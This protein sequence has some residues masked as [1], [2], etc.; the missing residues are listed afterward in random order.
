MKKSASFLVFFII[1]NFVC[2][3]VMAKVITVN[4]RLDIA[5]A[6]YASLQLAY[7]NATSGDTI[8]LFPSEIAYIGIDIS[9][10]LFL[11]GNGFVSSNYLPITIISGN[12]NFLEGSDGSS[13]ES[14]G[15]VFNITVKNVNNILISKNNINSLIIE[16]SFNTLL[17]SNL[18]NGSYTLGDFLITLKGNSLVEAKSNIIRARGIPCGYSS[19]CYAGAILIE[20][21]SVM[22]IDNS[23]IYSEGQLTIYGGIAQGKNNI[24]YGGLRSNVDFRFSIHSNAW[25]GQL[26]VS[27][28]NIIVSDISSIFTDLSNYNYHLKSGSEAIGNGEDGTDM[29]IYGGDT[30]FVDGG[31]PG[32]PVIYY[33]DV[34]LKGSQKQGINVTIK[35]KSNQ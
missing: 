3:N 2:H 21:S 25:E 7:D 12:V 19:T 10:R 23:I 14:F 28:N 32:I 20:G 17:L 15:G 31:Y 6:D 13:I 9:K 26:D 18:I 29:G 16:N 24:I 8:M 30:P 22:K 1:L 27:K 35:A 34:P 4:N 11:I 5:V 33:L